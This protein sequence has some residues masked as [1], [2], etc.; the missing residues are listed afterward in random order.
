MTETPDTEYELSNTRPKT[1]ER[2]LNRQNAPRKVLRYTLDL[3]AQQHQFLKLFAIQH[4]VVGSK[5]M[6]TMLYLLEADK[7]FADRVL[8][9]VFSAA[10][11]E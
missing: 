7:V 3:E 11:P 10:D 1:A 8:N 5:V 2:R 9:E 4:G 6:R